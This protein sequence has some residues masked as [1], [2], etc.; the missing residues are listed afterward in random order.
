MTDT[1]TD[2]TDHITE[3]PETAALRSEMRALLER[4]IDALP[5]QFRTVFMM[6]EV[7]ELSVDETATILDVPPETVRSRAFRARAM[8][9]EALSRD[10]DHAT[11]EAF[12]FDGARCDRLVAGVLSRLESDATDRIAADHN[13]KGNR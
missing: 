8:L 4:K 3:R 7:Q 11:L 10:I 9:R 5:E 12:N 6:R 2:M 13:P 1:T